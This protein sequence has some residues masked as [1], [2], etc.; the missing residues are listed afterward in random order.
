MLKSIRERRAVAVRLAS[1]LMIFYACLCAAVADWVP[2]WIL[3]LTSAM[4]TARYIGYSHAI[5]HRPL[6]RWPAA[7]E[8]LTPPITPLMPS[9]SQARA[10]HLHHHATANESEDPERWATSG[11]SAPVVFF[12]C[13][14]MY[15]SWAVFAL[16][17]WPVTRATVAGVVWRATLVAMMAAAVGPGA[18]VVAC[19]APAK[20]VTAYA[21]WRV[22]YL[23]HRRG[24][25]PGFYDLPD[26]AVVQLLRDAVVG[27]YATDAIRYHAR[28]HA[29]PGRSILELRG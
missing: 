8:L 5:A 21:F 9:F 27:R 25:V 15:E 18:F 14:F 6:P 22:S 7:Y 29:H 19:L 2:L 23:A 28:H 3:A 16:R 13:A 1:S 26:G 10:V 24:G 17:K 11:S 20:L 4:V 12:R